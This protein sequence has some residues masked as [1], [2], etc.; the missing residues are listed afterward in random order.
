MSVS[1]RSF[2]ETWS[3]VT[4][5]EPG[6]DG[7]FDPGANSFAQ[8]G[9]RVQIPIGVNFFPRKGRFA[10]HRLSAEWYYPV[11]QDLNGPQVTA[12]RTLVVSWQTFF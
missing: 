10:G 3:D 1:L 9:E 8:G 11:H 2:Y 12:D 4:G 7:A 5:S 6:T